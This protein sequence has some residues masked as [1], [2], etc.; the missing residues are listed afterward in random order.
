[1]AYPPP[2]STDRLVHWP[3]GGRTVTFGTIKIFAKGEIFWKLPLHIHENGLE[4]CYYLVF[5]SQWDFQWPNF[6][7]NAILHSDIMTRHLFFWPPFWPQNGGS[8]FIYR[9]VHRPLTRWSDRN[10][11]V[12]GRLVDKGVPKW[13]LKWQIEKTVTSICL[14]ES[15][16]PSIKT[17]I[18]S[19]SKGWHHSVF[20]LLFISRTGKNHFMGAGDISGE[21][22]WYQ[23]IFNYKFSML[24]CTK[25][26]ELM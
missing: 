7:K 14:K 16:S 20:L 19:H 12:N 4:M 15:E 21:T 9:L 10:F 8:V 6:H 23:E 24:V 5:Q 1:M 22:F 2:L 26:T 17:S 3:L 18:L 11:L 13:V 25:H